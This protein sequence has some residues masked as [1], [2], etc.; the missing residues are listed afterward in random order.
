M[1]HSMTGFGRGQATHGG[2]AVIVELRAVNNRF[3]DVNVRL[4]RALNEHEAAIQQRL[5]AAFA[6]GRINVQVQVEYTSAEAVPLQ[7]NTATAQAYARALEALRDAAG[8]DDAVRLD[9]LLKYPDVFTAEESEATRAEA[10][11]A[12]Q[13]ALE[14]AIVQMRAMRQQE[15]EALRSALHTQATAI[16]EGL[17]EARAIAPGRIEA[18]RTRLRERLDELAEDPRIQPERLEQEIA[19]VADKLDVTEEC[20]RLQSHLDLFAEAL[21]SDEPVGRKLTFIAQEMNREINTIGS[22]ANDAALAHCVVG[23]KESL[24]K[25]RE[26]VEN[27]E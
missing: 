20:V 8:L 17:A 14:A 5:Q 26:Q 18:T 2:V 7:V 13:D 9:H 22:K 15:G 16:A 1:I 19:L 4:P 24:E 12:V 25:I 10:W 6:R 23:M 21:T 27:V 3:C 11:Q